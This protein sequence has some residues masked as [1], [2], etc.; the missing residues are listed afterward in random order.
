MNQVWVPSILKLLFL[1]QKVRNE[2]H[3]ENDQVKKGSR[4]KSMLPSLALLL[5][6]KHLDQRANQPMKVP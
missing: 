2:S 3:N 5:L 6:Q 1:T 4:L